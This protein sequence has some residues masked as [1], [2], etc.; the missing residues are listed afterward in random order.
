MQGLCTDKLRQLPQSLRLVQATFTRVD[1]RLCT[2][3]VP[4]TMFYWFAVEAC[5]RAL[6]PYT[7][8]P[9]DSAVADG[10]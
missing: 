9:G 1:S 10:V 7:I 2:L 4:S 5:R 6:E 3:Q 8:Q